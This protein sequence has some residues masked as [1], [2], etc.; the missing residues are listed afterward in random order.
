MLQ[1]VTICYLASPT[2]SIN[3]KEKQ[4]D[5]VQHDTMKGNVNVLVPTSADGV[6]V[7]FFQ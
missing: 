6:V 3:V 7:V 2:A 1:T 5:R 4:Q